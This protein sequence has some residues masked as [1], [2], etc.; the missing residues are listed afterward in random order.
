MSQAEKPSQA[1]VS[2]RVPT[3]DDAAAIG[4]MHLQSCLETYP[5]SVLGIDEAWV[6]QRWG[7]FATQEGTDHRRHLIKAAETNVDLLYKVAE[8]DEHIV[9]FVHATRGPGKN[10]LAGLYTLAAYHGIGVGPELMAAAEDFFDRALPSE[11]EVAADNKRAVAFYQKFGFAVV[12][13]SEH[14]FCEKIPV[15]VMRRGPLGYS[16]SSC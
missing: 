4:P 10:I 12:A 2:V 13:G 8:A 7:K 9:G 14:L 6:R 16:A 3:V 5:N 11:L 1:R 15:V